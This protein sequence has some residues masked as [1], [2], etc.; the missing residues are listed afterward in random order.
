LLGLTD[1][2][3]YASVN[4]SLTQKQSFRAVFFFNYGQLVVSTLL[5]FLGAWCFAHTYL[6]LNRLKKREEHG[7]ANY[8]ELSRVALVT[9]V[10]FFCQTALFG[11]YFL[12]LFTAGTYGKLGLA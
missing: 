6:Q 3:V 8:K 7:S 1:W 2:I 12:G 5:M 9:G 10:C 11:F 4:E